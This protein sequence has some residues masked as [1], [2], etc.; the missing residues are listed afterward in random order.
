MT[1]VIKVRDILI[2]GGNDI[3]IQSMTNTFTDDIEKTVAQIKE[4]E[5]AG[6]QLVRMTINTE[7]AAK[8]ISV[9]KNRVNIPLVADIHF[10]YKLALMAIENGI[11]KL[12]LNPE[13]IGSDDKVELVVKKALEYKIPIRIGVNSGSIEKH[14]LEKYGHPTSDGLVESAMYHVK[15]LEKFGFEDII[16]SVKSSNVKMM[17]EAYRKLSKETNYPLHLGVTEAGTAFQGTVKS[18]I[19]IGSLLV[20]GIGDTIRVSLTENPVEE[21]KVAKEILQVL[22]H[23]KGTEIISCP[24]CGRTEIDLIGLAKQVE[25]EFKGKN[26]DIK[27]AVM[28]CVVNGP[29]EAKEADYGVAGGKGVGIL[30]KKGEIIKRVKESEILD[31]LKKLIRADFGD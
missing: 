16:I 26:F 7:A 15:L 3:V 31:E 29:G 1:K 24:T 14:I 20:D 19:G 28:G 5:A 10:D 11:D 4:L 2:G 23:R 12:R 22:E 25:K 18:S 30:F 9:I 21:I 8:S 27:I 17:V 6:C 13:N